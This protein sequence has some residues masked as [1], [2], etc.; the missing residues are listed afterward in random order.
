MVIVVVGRIV[1]IIAVYYASLKIF[2]KQTISFNELMFIAYGGMIR[3]AIAFALVMKIPYAG[4][5]NCKDE[6]LCFTKDEYDLAVS[7]T[8]AMVMLTTLIFG[9]FM[10]VTSMALTGG[11]QEEISDTVTRK[12]GKSQF[13][14]ATRYHEL[15]HPNLENDDDSPNRLEEEEEADA[16]KEFARSPLFKWF[17]NFDAT[18]LRPILIRRYEEEEVIQNKEL[19]KL[20]S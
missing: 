6:A 2:K 3:G 4:S 18:V 9:T 14:V 16:P 17:V 11:V 10:K 13:T 12:T 5:H 19:K 20:I 1:A 15:I 7:T 8:L